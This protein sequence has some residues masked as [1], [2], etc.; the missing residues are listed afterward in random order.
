MFNAYAEN[1]TSHIEWCVNSTTLT[2]SLLTPRRMLRLT[3]QET[4]GSE[5]LS[6]RSEYG[7]RATHRTPT[8][9]VMRMLGLV[10]FVPHQCANPHL[11]FLVRSSLALYSIIYLNALT[12]LRL[13]GLPLRLPFSVV[14]YIAFQVITHAKPTTHKT[15]AHN[16]CD[17]VT[18]QKTRRITFHLSQSPASTRPSFHSR[19]FQRPKSVR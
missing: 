5:Y 7:R 15:T 2:H 4:I 18:R 14:Q 10:L 17:R 6:L 12:F 3:C 13:V 9:A 19:M 1:S 11:F 8:L 16:S